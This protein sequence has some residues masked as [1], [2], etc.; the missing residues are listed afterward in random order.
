MTNSNNTNTSN[1]FDLVANGYG[2][3]NKV[4]F[5][6]PEKGPKYLIANLCLLSGA[7]NNPSKTYVYCTVK[8]AEAHAL[9]TD[10]IEKLQDAIK[11]KVQVAIRVEIGDLTTGSYKNAKNE[12][13]P[14]LDARVLRISYLRIG[15]KGEGEVLFSSSTANSNENPSEGQ[16]QNSE[17]PES[18]NSAEAKPESQVP[19]EPEANAIAES[20]GPTEAEIQAQ[21]DRE[22]KRKKAEA[23]LAAA[24]AAMEALEA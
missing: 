10:N 12:V 19:V 13:V 16:D 20:E 8:G 7:V 1:F 6:T 11:S 21:K 22:E 3:L 9:L 17:A 15:K 5:I 24:Q 14:K 23:A 18:V 2:Y 4:A